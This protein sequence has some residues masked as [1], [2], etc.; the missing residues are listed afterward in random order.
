MRKPAHYA[1]W[2]TDRLMRGT[3]SDSDAD[4]VRD[5]QRRVDIPLYLSSLLRIWRKFPRILKNFPVEEPNLEKATWTFA[6]KAKNELNV[7]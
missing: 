2:R 4:T 1:T 3:D 6:S 7:S 5:S